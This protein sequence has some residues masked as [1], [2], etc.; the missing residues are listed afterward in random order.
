MN[1]ETLKQYSNDESENLEA[2]LNL[3]LTDGQP[4]DSSFSPIEQQKYARS[5]LAEAT[6]QFY[7]DDEILNSD[8]YSVSEFLPYIS[9]PNLS[10]PEKADVLR[11]ADYAKF[12]TGQKV[13]NTF[14]FY[15]D[16]SDALSTIIKQHESPNQPEMSKK[17]AEARKLFCADILNFSN[18]VSTT[19]R[20]NISEKFFENSPSF[21][22]NCGNMKDYLELI[23]IAERSSGNPCV[24]PLY[25]EIVYNYSFSEGNEFKASIEDIPPLQQLRLIPIITNVVNYTGGEGWDKTI[26]QKAA[27]A[28][29]SLINEDTT[30]PLVQIVAGDALS[31]IG[32]VAESSI[33][34]SRDNQ[35][36]L[37]AEFPGLADYYDMPGYF[38]PSDL[39]KIA[40]GVAATINNHGQIN[41]IA[42][43]NGNR[44]SVLKYDDKNNLNLDIEVTE[45][46]GV[47][48]NPR[49]KLLINREIGLN[50]SNISLDAQAQLLK[51]MTEAD[52][53]RFD[54]LCS[55]L[56]GV[57]KTLRLKL[58]EGFLATG[59]GEDFGDALLDIAGSE[60]INDEQLSEILDK[61]NSCRESIRNI[62]ELYHDFDGGEFAQ[63]YA[64]AVNERLTDT[65]TVFREIAL[66]GDANSDLGWF[67][68]VGFDY[69]SAMEALEYEAKSLEIISGTLGDVKAKK[70]GAF[71]EVVLTRDEKMS[72]LDRTMYNFYSPEHEYVLLYTRGE[73]SGS[74]DSMVEYGKIRSKYD[75]TNNN[76]GVEASISLIVNPVDPF[77]L[78]SPF[79]P[80][81]KKVKDLGYYDASTMDKVSAIR[82][83]RE[84]RAPGASADDPNRDPINEA[85]TISVDLAAINDRADTPSG[86]IARLFSVGNKLRSEKANRDTSL[87]H[88]THWFNQDKYG[89]ANGFKGLVKYVDSLAIS[90]CSATPPSKNEG[91]TGLMRRQQNRGRGRKAASAHIAA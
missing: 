84:G 77:S 21:V 66:D 70:E 67:G 38:E 72:R 3:N 27:S 64:R 6:T 69:D 76:S 16:F 62:T 49:I 87:N 71:A 17:V 24:K 4:L 34:Y 83:D 23:S 14:E 88:N 89:T 73:G 60:R 13:E 29:R 48:H 31:S 40:P 57:D 8:V 2:W 58:A 45:L 55:T 35:N 80:D 61:M 25:D 32:N 51:Y 91:F 30:A 26:S 50:I 59:F 20:Q 65:L 75:K 78:P 82:L 10:D 81:H 42:D 79:R 53:E 68:E 37:R 39:T 36:E 63:E 86:K 22:S 15:H 19:T 7:S 1:Y 18:S 54:K 9:I 41:L 43:S 33:K 90:W 44:V 74:F 28:F 46:L 85:G 47:A 52:D 11:L 5:L 56:H 12:A